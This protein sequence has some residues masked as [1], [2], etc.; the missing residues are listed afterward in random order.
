MTVIDGAFSNKFRHDDV[1]ETIIILEN[2]NEKLLRIVESQR[3]QQLKTTDQL[4]IMQKEHDA[5][6]NDISVTNQWIDLI[7]GQWNKTI[8]SG[9]EMVLKDARVSQLATK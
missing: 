1:E 4:L 8:E 6:N 7:Q 3:K 2:K 9:C 5:S